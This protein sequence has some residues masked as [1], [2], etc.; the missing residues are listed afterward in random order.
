MDALGR[1]LSR[2]QEENPVSGENITLAL[3]SRLQN[4]IMDAMGE[5]SGCVVVMEPESG[6]L[7][8]LVTK[9]TYDNNI[10]IGGL[11]SRDWEALSNN[12]RYP[13]L[14]RG[15]QSVYPPGSVWKIMMSSMLL[16]KGV[17]P[18]EKVFC[19]GSYKVGN[20]VFRC[21]RA[22]GHG[23]VDMEH[24]LIGSCDVYFY[25]MGEKY[26]INAIEQ[27][28]GPADTVRLPG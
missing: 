21:W 5:Y 10:F 3:D 14:N 23:N 7:R 16:E 24:A 27:H 11:S 15:I 28:A 2:T 6:K 19:P 18:H 1:P 17:S 9:P 4:A 25:A 8:A 20:R 13:L 26:G 12:P 22:G